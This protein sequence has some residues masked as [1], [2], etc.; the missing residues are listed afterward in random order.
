LFPHDH[1]LDSPDFTPLTEKFWW[2]KV[3]HEVVKHADNQSIDVRRAIVADLN[4]SRAAFELSPVFNHQVILPF[5]AFW[6][7]Y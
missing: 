3:D 1:D 2:L 5:K 6:K 7:P 4:P